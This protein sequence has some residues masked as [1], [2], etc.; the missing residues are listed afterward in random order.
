MTKL[1]NV[2]QFYLCSSL[3]SQN[4]TLV[5]FELRVPLLLLPIVQF[6]LR[7]DIKDKKKTCK[8]DSKQIHN[9]NQL[10]N[11]LTLISDGYNYR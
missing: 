10:D 5:I 2:S 11:F 7:V 4:H 9:S 1:E 6:L 3:P 8:N